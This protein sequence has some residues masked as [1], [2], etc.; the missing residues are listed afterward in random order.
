MGFDT[1]YYGPPTVSKKPEVVPIGI[2]V[3]KAM[4][5]PYMAGIMTPKTGLEWGRMEMIEVDMDGGKDLSSRCE[6]SNIGITEVR[7]RVEDIGSVKTALKS[8]GVAVQMENLA[9]RVKTPDGA[10]ITFI[11]DKGVE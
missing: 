8:R 7:F 2:P 6:R 4:T 9:V 3:D 1:F 11:E 5:T 10:N